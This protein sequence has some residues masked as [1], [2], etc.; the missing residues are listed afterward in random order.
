MWRM[1]NISDV[2]VARRTG[3]IKSRISMANE[4]FSGKKYLFNKKLDLNLSKKL[5]RC[6]LEHSFV[7]S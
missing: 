6:C 2:C 7:W 3:E 4:A 1:W 5:V